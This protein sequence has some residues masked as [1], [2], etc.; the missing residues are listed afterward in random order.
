MLFADTLTRW[1]NAIP[2]LGPEVAH[3]RR[4][5]PRKL[6]GAE[7][8]LDVQVQVPPV[9]I[10]RRAFKVVAFAGLDPVFASLPDRNA[11][12]VGGVQALA[13]FDVRRGIVGVGFLLAGKGLD[14]SLALLVNV[15][16]DPS[17]LRLALRVLPGALSD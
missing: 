10:E 16:D 9:L 5:Q 11:V 14:M 12:A 3:H 2:Q 6:H 15:I 13:H 4:V 8:R 17:I 7:V 1:R